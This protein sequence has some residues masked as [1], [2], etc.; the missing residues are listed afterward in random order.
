MWHRP[1]RF[2]QKR[3]ATLPCRRMPCGMASA[4]PCAI[5]ESASVLRSLL[6]APGIMACVSTVCVT[7]PVEASPK[8]AGHITVQT[9]AMIPGAFNKLQ[10]TLADSVMA[11]GRADAIPL[12]IHV[13]YIYMSMY[14]FIHFHGRCCCG[15]SSPGC[16][17]LVTCGS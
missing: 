1:S 9:H 11:Q 15:S 14:T 7:P 4:R 17:H 2:P 16:L 5:T 10:H 6:K 8:E 12:Y 13:S 3:L